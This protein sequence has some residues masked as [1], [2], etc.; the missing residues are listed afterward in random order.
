MNE[1]AGNLTERAEFY[2]CLARAFLP[3]RE[4]RD[5]H[6]IKEYLAT[7]LA[8]LG[9][10]IGYPIGR[11]LERLRAALARIT[12]QQDLLQLY[13]RLFLVP[14]TPAHLNAGVYL[15]GGIMGGSVLQIENCYRRF[16]LAGAPGFHDTPDH[17]GSL[18]E[19][20]AFLHASARATPETAG[21]TGIPVRPDEARDFAHR[22]LASWLPAFCRD[23]D[24]ATAHG[25]AGVYAALADVLRTAVTQDLAR[26]AAT[27]GAPVPAHP[28]S[29]A[30]K[31]G[32]EAA[33]QFHCILGSVGAP[34]LAHFCRHCGTAFVPAQEMQ[35]ILLTLKRSGL[36]TEHL[37]LCPD[38]RTQAMGLSSIPT[39]DP[40]RLRH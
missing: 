21:A 3:P 14:P 27:T 7:E 20:L 36:G 35:A 39:P 23:L 26:T 33:D 30:A 37:E 16:G 40:K 22:Y 31:P 34:S 10:A 38:C 6:A 12:D 2:L 17:L 28:D 32:P 13:S 1:P 11:A 24:A 18:L 4:E 15:D 9:A 19:F 25:P 5:F 29:S 8:E